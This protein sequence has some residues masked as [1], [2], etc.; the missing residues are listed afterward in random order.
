MQGVHLRKYGVAAVIDFE[1]FEVDGVDFRVDAVDG[2][3]DS[4]IRKNQG[5]DATCTNDFVDEGL[6]YSLTLTATEMQAASIVLHIVD[7]TVTKVWLDKTIVI[8]TYGNASAMHAMDFD[9]IV[10]GGL[11]AL[12][13]AVADGP[14]GLPVSD[15]G[16]FDVDNRAISAAATVNMEDMFDGTGYIA[17][18]APASRSQ[19]SAIA[20]AP[21]VGA[22]PFV[23]TDITVTAGTGA[24]GSAADMANDDTL[25]YTLDDAAGT[26][27]LDL[28][29]QLDAGV[30]VVSYVLTAA[31]Q[32]N[33][34]DLT[35]Q[36]YDQV[37]L[38]Y[39]TFDTLVGA[40][41]LTYAA[42]DKTI[43]SKYTTANGL[44][45]VRITGTGLTAATL[46]INKAVA[47]GQSSAA[48]VIPNGSEITLNASAANRNL[49]GNNWSLILNNQNLSN[50]YIQG[51]EGVSGIMT[52]PTGPVH[53]D[54]CEVGNVTT[55][56]AHFHD[57]GF[58]GTLTLG[59]A[60]AFKIVGCNT[61]TVADGFIVIDGN[62][63][64]AAT[65]VMIQDF[66]GSITFNNLTSFHTITC[67]GGELG[68]IILNGADATVK[69]R[70]QYESLTNNLTGT[71][72]VTARAIK[73]EDIA[74]TKA[75]T[76]QM[77]FT[78]ANELDVNTKSM[79]DAEVIGNGNAIPWDGV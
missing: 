18:T 45:Q 53:L 60:G 8:E 21:G 40:N 15:A 22:R 64:G 12:P 68:N 66:K 58:T 65:S 16:G 10:R 52:T 4:T 36:I 35:L 49:T 14:G 34:D 72:T 59:S 57:S 73:A 9:D 23:P 2:G 1:L 28:D 67:S 78:K 51:A 32:G 70:G 62:S 74:A 44:F 39:D 76:D 19:I 29:Y 33:T 27:T 31:A 54:H 61:E 69:I 55:G 5:P 42:F 43:V 6:S 75:V 30:S 50:A 79:N 77:V 56:P 71:P 63:L 11:T 13:N 38:G 37:G 7:Q 46:T 25:L 3:A 41:G 17:D 48:S 20:A 47:Y 24:S 26:L